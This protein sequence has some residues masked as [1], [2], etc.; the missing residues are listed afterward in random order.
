MALN[1]QK[2]KIIVDEINKK[3]SNALSAIVA[4]SRGVKVDAMTSLRKQARE[5]GIYVRVVRN[6]LARRAILGTNFECLI[7]TF[8]GPTLIA[9]SNEHPGSAARL[10]KKFTKEN[11]NFKIK[12]ASFEGVVADAE[13]LAIL[14]T[15]NE[16]IAQLTVCMREA[17]AGKLVRTIAAI[18][19]R[20]EVNTA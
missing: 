3:A 11:T 14:P 9:F 18:R 8:T 12:A 7:D 16:A 6:T 20:K 10:L 4:N 19:N 13:M 5:N 2:K 17:S 15:Y 1:L